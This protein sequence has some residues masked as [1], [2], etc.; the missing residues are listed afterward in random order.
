[1]HSSQNS[2][3]MLQAKVDPVGGRWILSKKGPK[4]RPLLTLGGVGDHTVD[5][6]L[7]FGVPPENFG[8]NG[9]NEQGGKSVASKLSDT[10]I[11]KKLHI[12]Q[13]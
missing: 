8:V 3:D 1:M 13:K 11:R 9:S 7:T 10:Q 2:Y 6:R 4:N 5:T 12:F